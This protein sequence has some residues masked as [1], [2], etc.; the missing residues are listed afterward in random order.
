M[1]IQLNVFSASKGIAMVMIDEQRK[2]EVEIIPAGNADGGGY[3]IKR[4]RGTSVPAQL[5]KGD[6]ISHRLKAR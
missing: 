2:R 5:I 6:D 1:L 3:L 4:V